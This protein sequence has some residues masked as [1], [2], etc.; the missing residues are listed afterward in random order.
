MSPPSLIFPRANANDA[1]YG[2]YSA[3]GMS[4]SE[5]DNGT[6]LGHAANRGRTF[7]SAP[8]DVALSEGQ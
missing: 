8:E 2:A 4:Y 1:L 7:D 5:A 6:Q 3:A